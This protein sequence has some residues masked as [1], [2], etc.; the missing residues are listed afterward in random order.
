MYITVC[1][2]EKT[3]VFEKMVEIT[4]HVRIPVDV[5]SKLREIEMFQTEKSYVFAYRWK[6]TENAV[7]STTFNVSK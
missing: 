7:K 2:L 4:S 5:F 6:S 3:F 1:D